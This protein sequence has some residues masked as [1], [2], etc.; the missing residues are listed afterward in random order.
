MQRLLVVAMCMHMHMP[1]H[2]CTCTYAA[3]TRRGHVGHDDVSRIDPLVL[4][5]VSSAL[6]AALEVL[7]QPP[8]LLM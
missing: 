5:R 6:L 3:L 2:L 1:M 7:L 8:L 4:L